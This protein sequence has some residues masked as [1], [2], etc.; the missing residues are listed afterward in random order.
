MTSACSSETS[1][2]GDWFHFEDMNQNNAIELSVEVSWKTSKLFLKPC[3]KCS[4]FH[5][6][7]E[8][9]GQNS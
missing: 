3:P 7:S 5:Y 1:L 2:L 9:G 6:I 8:I 4:S